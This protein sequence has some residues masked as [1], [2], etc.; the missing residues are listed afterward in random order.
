MKKIFNIALFLALII[1]STS[2]CSDF[3]QYD[4]TSVP[5]ESV[6]WQKKSDFQSAL[7][8]CYSVVYQWPGALSQII[9]CLDNLTDNGISKH[10]DSTYGSTHTMATGDISPTSGGFVYCVYRDCYDGIARANILLSKLNEYTGS[11]MTDA[12]KKV[13]VAECKAIRGYYYQWL[14]SCY[15]EVPLVT[16]PLTL[17]NMYMEKSTRSEIFAQIVSDYEAAIADLPDE[18]YNSTDVSGHFTAE[19]VKGLEARLYLNEAYDDNGN[20]SK[21][22]YLNK[23]VS[24]CNA[25][26]TSGQYSLAPSMHYNFLA[27]NQL[28][29][30]EIMFSVRYA[31]P[32]LLNY[33]EV[34]Y[35]AWSETQVTRD[36][37][38][39]FECTDGQKWGV[40][41]LTVPVDETLVN[42][43]DEVD[44]TQ[45]ERLK[46]FVNRDPRM[47]ATLCSSGY[48]V[49]PEGITTKQGA[50]GTHFAMTKVVQPT[51]T[52][53]SYDNLT[54][55]DADV[56]ILRY[57]EVLLDLAEA[58]NELNGPTQ[59]VYDAVNAIRLRSN[60][61]AL[62]TGLTKDQMRER[63]RHEW[64]VETSYEGLR[65]FQ[66][67]RWKLMDK[68]F[69]GAVDPGLAGYT[70]V[71]KPAFY[72][73]PIPQS[74]ID[75]AN[76]VLTQ[77]P[78]YQ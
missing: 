73:W 7:A 27:A 63:I 40:S 12:E 34:Y 1:G 50:S 30:K 11:D 17:D 37:V 39:D 60:M 58:E 13:M 72:F 45:A 8:A 22:D 33:M 35:G 5:S 41:P 59:T 46:L 49:F 53:I 32:N 47:V 25:I 48:M 31:K 29:P 38:N 52:T 66:L 19:A 42:G 20:A 68:L 21:T 78:N 65:Y 3:L 15:R 62:P 36:F 61:P 74:E 71:F 76:G 9:P 24:L 2:S 4:P 56:V 44:A 28:T 43:N 26:K 55:A 6:F 67:K 18:N 14:F 70:K 57:A 69:N 64:R 10:D 75:K 54:D 16:E 77:D 51:T 23:V